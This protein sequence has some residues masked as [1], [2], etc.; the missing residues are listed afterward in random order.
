MMLDCK[1]AVPLFIQNK[2]VITPTEV[3]SKL[4]NAS[5]KCDSR[6]FLHLYLHSLFE[7]NPHAGKDF[8][9]LQ[10]WRTLDLV[11][12]A[13]TMCSYSLSYWSKE[14]FMVH[15]NTV[16]CSP[17]FRC[18]FFVF[19]LVY[20]GKCVWW[21][22]LK[23]LLP[24]LLLWKVELYAD[25][26]QKMLLPFLRSSQHYMLEKVEAVNKLTMRMIT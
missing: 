16:C 17:E 19:T 9:D 15:L 13:F 5:N 2:D 4:L 10:V 11:L 26:D 25:Y 12:I 24:V 3:V 1:H 6:Y 18:L 23:T 7:V 8:H 20:V 14:L 21:S 22:N